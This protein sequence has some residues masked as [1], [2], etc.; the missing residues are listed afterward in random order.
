MSKISK[1]LAVLEIEKWLDFKKVKPKKREA[2]KDAIESLTDYVAEGILVLNE[3]FSLTQ[4]LDFPIGIEKQFKSLDYKARID[5][6]TLQRQMSGVSTGDGRILA[7]IAALTGQEKA[8]VSKM[9]TEDYSVA[10][11]IAVFFL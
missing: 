9:D 3:D 1:E 11:S 4:N 7:T 10:S 8:I 2:Y 5:V 6:S